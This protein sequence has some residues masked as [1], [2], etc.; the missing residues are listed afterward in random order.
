MR[1]F[2]RHDA[3]C[4]DMLGI[5][6]RSS[7]RATSTNVASEN[8]PLPNFS[9]QHPTCRNTV[10]KRTKHVASNN[11]AIC[12]V[13][14]WRLFGRDFKLKTNKRIGVVNELSLGIAT[15]ESLD[16]ATVF[17]AFNNFADITI[18]LKQL[19]TVTRVSNNIE[20]T[21]L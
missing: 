2:G 19:R 8:W 15:V 18:K 7:A 6:N 20:V 1:P 10:A 5:E 17:Q 21:L 14:I 12:C 13:E 3:T 9:Q 4:F 16:F 11:V